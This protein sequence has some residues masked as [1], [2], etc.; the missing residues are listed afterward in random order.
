MVLVTPPTAPSP[1]NPKSTGS[2]GAV[3]PLPRRSNNSMGPTQTTLI[4]NIAVALDGLPGEGEGEAGADLAG[5]VE[6]A[7]GTSDAVERLE[8]LRSACA[9]SSVLPCLPGEGRG[10]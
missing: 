4:T 6:D 9:H 3:P 2:S 8:L 7:F 10:G 5:L 1:A